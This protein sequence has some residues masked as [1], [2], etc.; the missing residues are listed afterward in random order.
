VG[1]RLLLLS[2]STQHGRGYLD[3]AAGAI[4]AVLTGIPEL[5]FDPH[6]QADHEGYTRTARDRFAAWGVRVRGLHETTDPHAAVGAAQAIFVGGGNTF[7]LLRALQR[8]RV[9]RPFAEAVRSGSLYLGAS[10]GTNLACPTI[11]TTNDMPI[12]EPAGLDALGLISFQINPHYLDPPP[13]S[14]H[15]GETRERR[16]QEFH[17]ENDLPVLGLREG[18][19]LRVEDDGVHLEGERPARLLRRGAEPI[20]LDPPAR[21]ESWLR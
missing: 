8:M 18:S 17:E 3:H 12:V 11:R 14:R 2:N 15:M 19:W 16:L 5:L 9:L 6:A 21:I 13:D 20:E 7:R 1:C 4:R 10:A